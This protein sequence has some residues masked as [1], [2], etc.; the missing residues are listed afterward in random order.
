MGLSMAWTAALAA[1]GA[2]E[3]P[4]HPGRP[5]CLRDFYQLL[6]VK[7]FTYTSNHYYTEYINS[8]WTPGGNLCL[9]DLATGSV[10]ELVPQLQGGVFERFDLSF[11]ARRV[12]F[13]W[14]AS[15]QVG[16]RIFEIGLDGT[17]LRQL[18][19]PQPDEEELVRRYR[20]FPHYHHGTDDMHPCYLPDG[21]IAFIS[22]RC[23]YGILCDAPDDFT[24]TVLYRMDADGGNLRRLSNSSVSEASPVMLPDGRIMYTRWEYID[25]G[26]VSVKCLWAMR[27]DGTASAEIYGNDIA[28]PP[29]LIYGRPIPG[30]PNRYVVLGTP[31]CPQNGI[32]TVIR[33]DMNRDIRSRDPMTYLTPDV[34]IQAEPGFAFREGNGPWRHDPEGRGRLF[35]DPY[36]LSECQFLVAHKPA[37]P[38]W[39]D[40]K[41]YGLYLLD[42]QGRTT[43]VYRDPAISCWLPYPVKPRPVP[44]VVTSQR[45]PQLAAAKR[46][47]CTVTDVYRGLKDVPR[48][49]IKHI[50]VLEQIPRP[51][52]ARRRWDGDCYDQQHACITKDTHLGLKVQ[53]GVVP[54]EDDGSARFVVPAEANVFL[55]LLD[56]N[57]LAVQTERTFVN[58]MPG[59]TRSCVGCHETPNQTAV[60]GPVNIPKAMLRPPSVPGPQPGEASGRRALDY[61]ADVQPVWEKHC[62]ACHSG[63]RRDGKLDLSG[64]LTEMF[65]VSY[66]NLV[67][68]RRKGQFDRR[69]LGPV[70]GENHPKTGNVDYLPAYS[71]GSH[72]S[73]LIAMLQPGAVH[74]Q[75][76]VQAERV[77]R[78]VAAHDKLQL[79]PEELLRVSN[80]VDTNCQYYG[81]YWG[82]KNL[83]YRGQPDFRPVPS[84]ELATRMTAP[85]P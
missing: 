34:D 60:S 25:K 35:K 39:N 33:L 73:V 49:T 6:F 31:H 42:E 70:I 48:G 57:Y 47:L 3:P 2:A 10:R 81:T 30:V 56:A 68:E 82:R 23:Q 71:L 8:Q 37:G 27:P 43:L 32:G 14:K 21:G 41:A 76:P 17:G 22:T 5:D 54:V 12:V 85:S 7:R 13:A 80:W 58:Y 11:D 77:R 1:V 29:T 16:Y 72:A 83:R 50:R 64:E 9:L 79:T 84:F 46:A 66:E 74:L 53:H 24:T 44:P 75:D 4:A 28:L 52:A 59:E 36:P 63:A 20:V 18:T 67:P 69:L 55:Q 45:D 40:A 62:L 65:N 78:L 38:A 61:A 26:A 51:W 19:F 15:A